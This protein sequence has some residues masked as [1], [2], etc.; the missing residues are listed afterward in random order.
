MKLRKNKYYNISSNLY[1]FPSEAICK[2][3]EIKGLLKKIYKFEIV[4]KNWRPKNF[5]IQHKNINFYNI[6]E[7]TKKEIT[8]MKLSEV[9]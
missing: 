3:I 1:F 5:F 7:C 6:S 4:N 9:K 8:K 2:L